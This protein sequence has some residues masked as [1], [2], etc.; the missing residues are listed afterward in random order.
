MLA[1]Y[2][3]S[4]IACAAAT[5]LSLTGVTSPG[6]AQRSDEIWVMEIKQGEASLEFGGRSDPGSK[7]LGYLNQSFSCDSRGSGTMYINEG[8]PNAWAIEPARPA[9]GW[10]LSAAASAP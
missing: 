7:Q 2:R 8:M 4:R 5:I 1:I 3:I 10:S 9:P 6:Q